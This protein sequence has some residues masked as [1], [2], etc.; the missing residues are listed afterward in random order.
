MK[1]KALLTIIDYSGKG[2]TWLKKF[3]WM[4][5]EYS[6]VEKMSSVYQDSYESE[7]AISTEKPLVVCALLLTEKFQY[8]LL[9]K[10]IET[11]AKVNTEA[12][13]EVIRATLLAQEDCIVMTPKLALPHPRLF[14]HPQLLFPAAEVWPDYKHPI[15]SK[16]LI[17]M[18][19]EYE[20][21]RWGSYFAQGTSLLDFNQA[22]K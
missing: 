2:T 16:S 5:T 11:E 15:L 6:S 13:H 22:K 10:I 20:G 9:E 19:K 3:M 14:T 1:Y 8:E 7:G 12:T 18:T 21:G 17:E 4:T